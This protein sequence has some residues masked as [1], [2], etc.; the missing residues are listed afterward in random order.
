MNVTLQRLILTLKSEASKDC[1]SLLRSLH[2]RGVTLVKRNF[3]FKQCIAHIATGSTCDPRI[4]PTEGSVRCFTHCSSYQYNKLD[5]FQ[6]DQCNC[7]DPAQC[8][9]CFAWTSSANLAANVDVEERKG[10]IYG[11]SKHSTRK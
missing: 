1:P 3:F 6:L 8:S 9:R 7:T 5:C 11:Y 4:K 2:S 10:G